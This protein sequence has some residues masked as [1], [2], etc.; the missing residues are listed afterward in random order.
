MAAFS[1]LRQR[2]HRFGRFPDFY[3][4]WESF[5]FLQ[6]LWDY[7][8]TIEVQMDYEMTELEQICY[9][10]FALKVKFYSFES[11]ACGG[12]LHVM[13]D[14]GNMRDGDIEFSR[15]YIKNNKINPIEKIYATA[16]LDFL[17]LLSS[18]QRRV[19]WEDPHDIEGIVAAKN[20]DIELSENGYILVDRKIIEPIYVDLPETEIM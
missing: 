11:C 9:E 8:V 17:S 4:N 13:L 20:K 7:P 3:K 14:D 15:E 6:K 16:I 5:D 18:G 2:Y 10:L 12:C 1:N 19:W